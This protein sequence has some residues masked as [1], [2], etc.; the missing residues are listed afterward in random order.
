MVNH[1]LFT[2]ASVANMFC[3]TYLVGDTWT[4]EN[5]NRS[6][7]LIICNK[8]AS[9]R[10]NK[11][12]N[13]RA[14]KDGGTPVQHSGTALFLLIPGCINRTRMRATSFENSQTTIFIQTN[15]F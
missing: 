14:I 10:K 4:L 15:Q 7:S 6:D 12:L 8:M 2:G 13:F 9:Q 11:I 3:L 5:Q 1:Q